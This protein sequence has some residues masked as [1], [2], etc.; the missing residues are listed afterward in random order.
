MDHPYQHAD[1][2]FILIYV[3]AEGI[4]WKARAREGKMVDA[5]KE[6][7]QKEI[8]KGN[9][10]MPLRDAKDVVEAYVNHFKDVSRSKIDP[11]RIN[12]RVTLHVTPDPDGGYNVELVTKIAAGHANNVGELMQMVAS[13]TA[14]QN[15]P[16]AH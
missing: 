11:V 7:R 1:Y 14:Q 8:A 4:S 5:I 16:S 13:I 12:D 10:N 2:P 3:D 6:L 9:G 15:S